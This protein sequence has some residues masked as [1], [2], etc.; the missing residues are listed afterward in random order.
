MID[1]SD[2]P[3]TV[4]RMPRPGNFPMPPAQG[5]A[6][7]SLA[8]WL[9]DTPREAPPKS[10]YAPFAIN[11]WPYFDSDWRYVESIP[12]DDRT[13]VESLKR[14]HLGDCFLFSTGGAYWTRY[15]HEH[16]S[17]LT[18]VENDYNLQRVRLYGDLWYSD[19]L[20]VY[21]EYVWADSL[22]AE[23][24]PPPPDVDLGDIQDLFIDVK[25]LEYQG[26]PVY[27]RAGRQELLYGSQRL[28][29]P[30]PWANKRH[31][32]EGVKLFRQ[33]EQWDIDAFWTKYVPPLASEFDEVD[34]NQQLAGTW[35]TYRPKPGHFADFYYLMYD[36]QNAAVQQGIVRSP[37]QTHTFGARWAGDDAGRLW[38]FEGAMQTGRQ[39]GND[40]VAGMA[41]AGLGRNWKDTPLDP[42]VWV[43]YDYASGDGNP[44]VGDAHTFNPPFPFGHYYLGWMDLV[45]R[46]NIHDLNAHLY[47]YPTPWITVWLQYH[48]FWLADSQ[49]ALYNAGGVAYRRDPTGQAG[50]NVGDEVDLVVNFHVARYTDVLV[51]YNKLYGGR[52]LEATAG[53]NLSSDAETL[54]LLFQQRW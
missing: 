34:D 43:Y 23:L 37:F 53:P 6:Y 32:F 27:L 41:T 36:N 38:D 40:V 10:G 33:G 47:L 2:Y 13:L 46:Q 19:F 11:A 54:Y 8:D 28:V 12:P 30:L 18:Q 31:T 29:S 51:S 25:A 26:K 16:N 48:H 5:P 52:F 49:D 20:R 15:S 45:G 50:N 44:N 1:W 17:R 14:I 7:F 42:T 35:L 22:G 24:P 3:Q 21:G 39:A 9:T 4:R